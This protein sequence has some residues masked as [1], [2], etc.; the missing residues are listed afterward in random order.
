MYLL[1][2]CIGY[3]G[4]NSLEDYKIYFVEGAVNDLMTKM[5]SAHFEKDEAKKVTAI[6][7]IDLWRV[8]Y[9]KLY[10]TIL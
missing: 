10:D 4:K 5:V 8:Q 6:L 3:N 1:L 7:G 9:A 2:A